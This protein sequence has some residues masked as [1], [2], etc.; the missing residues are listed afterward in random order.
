MP[1]KLDFAIAQGAPGVNFS[2]LSSL[3][4]DYG[5]GQGLAQRSGVMDAFKAGVPTLADGSPDYAQM[6]A[7][8]FQLGDLGTAVQLARLATQREQMQASPTVAATA[9]G[10]AQMPHFTG[11]SRAHPS[12]PTFGSPQEAGASGLPSG[13]PFLTPDGRIKTI[14]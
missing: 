13:T 9:G 1:D 6:A 8:Y 7:R 12:L 11:T 5:A 3:L 2:P 14:P 10:A 4:G